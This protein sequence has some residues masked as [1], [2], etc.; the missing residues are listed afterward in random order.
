MHSSR[1]VVCKAHAVRPQVR[2]E[3]IA[4]DEAHFKTAGSL[5]VSL[6]WASAAISLC[7]W[8]RP[9]WPKHPAI[10]SY[11]FCIKLYIIYIAW[12]LRIRHAGVDNR[13]ILFGQS[14]TPTNDLS[15]KLSLQYNVSPITRFVTHTWPEVCLT[16][17]VMGGSD[18]LKWQCK[19]TNHSLACLIV[20]KELLYES[21]YIM[22]NVYGQFHQLSTT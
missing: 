3:C 9:T 18:I 17:P 10:S 11:W 16:K 13:M 14:S 2:Y 1:S 5:V 15:L 8:R 19:V 22:V 7:S 4:E 20:Q 12:N 21:M 6:A